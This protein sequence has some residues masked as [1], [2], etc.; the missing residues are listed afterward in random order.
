[1]I[2]PEGGLDADEVREQLPSGWRVEGGGSA[3]Y[4][5]ADGHSPVPLPR[6]PVVPPSFS[7]RMQGDLWVATWKD[8]HE[9]GDD[10]SVVADTARGNRE[11]CVE[12]IVERA[13]DVEAGGGE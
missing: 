3:V 5:Y 13:A 10:P 1:M 4:G 9:L 7:I 8:A 11:R 6:L 2:E 12:W